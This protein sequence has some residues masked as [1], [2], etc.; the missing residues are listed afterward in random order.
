[1]VVGVTAGK[2]IGGHF[3]RGGGGGGGAGRWAN[4]FETFIKLE[5]T[6]SRTFSLEKRSRWR[7]FLSPSKYFVTFPRRK[8]FP[9]I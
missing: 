2:L 9:Q 8:V 3:C 1:M 7:K 4:L 6:L 5:Y